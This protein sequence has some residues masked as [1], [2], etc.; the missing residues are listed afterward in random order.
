VCKYR[1]IFH[2]RKKI[3]KND[4]ARN[5]VYPAKKHRKSTGYKMFLYLHFKDFPMEIILIIIVLV[6]LVY[7]NNSLS[8]RIQKFEWRIMELTTLIE[9][10]KAEQKPTEA[11]APQTRPSPPVATPD[12]VPVPVKEEKPFEIITEK[13]ALPAPAIH[14]SP[15]PEHTPAPPP[16]REIQKSAWEKFK[17]KNPDL[18]KF[19][20]ENLINKIGVLILVLG[21]S[22]FVKF[23]I[24]KDWINEPARVG[25]GILCGALVMGFAHRLRKNFAAFSSVLVAGA[26]SIFYFTIGIAFHDYHLFGQTAAFILMVLITAFSSIISLSYNRLELAILTLIGGFAVP[27]MV[28][29]GEGNFIILFSY[30]AILDAG[31]LAIAYHKKWK[32][33]NLLSYIFTILLYG[34]WLINDLS[35]EHPHYMGALLFGFLFYLMFI[36]INI[37]NNIRTKGAFSATQL[38]M[39]VSNTFLFYA[40]GMAIFSGFHPEMRGLFT[41]CLALLNFVYAWFLYKRFGADKTTVYLLVGMTLTFVTLAIPIQFEGNFITLFW[42]AEAVLLMWLGRKSG[43]PGFRFASAAVHLLMIISLTMDWA[44]KYSGAET[45]KIIINPAFVTGI[46]AVLSLAAVSAIL[47]GDSG[48]EEKTRWLFPTMRYRT[49]VMIIAVALGYL[50]G[51]FEISHQAVAYMETHAAAK[52]LPVVYHLLFCSA[53]VFFLMWRKNAASYQAITLIAALNIVLYA[54]WFSR[55]PYLEHNEYIRT[56]VAQQTAFYLHYAALLLIIYLALQLYHSVRYLK[57]AQPGNRNAFVWISAFFLIYIASSELMLHW[58]V[59]A[60]NPVTPQDLQVAANDPIIGTGDAESMLYTTAEAKT[61]LAKLQ[62]MKT[63]FPI[64]WGVIAFLFL[65]SGIRKKSR[66]LRIISLTLLGITIVKLFLYDIRNASETGKIIAF[67]L[68]G[69]LILVISFVYQKLKV[70]VLNDSQPSDNEF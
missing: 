52:M 41:T 45:L 66:Q 62:A 21:I 1:I 47:K 17:E 14:T 63:G 23:A 5:R 44:D 12:P 8:A 65:I 3:F 68:L 32:L 10:L 54:F 37:I 22:Y 30:I 50:T 55:Y 59:I 29:T 46:F 39:L 40:A 36:L 38:G 64:L 2:F 70:L 58:L 53:L 42:A 56:N 16:V 18:E 24:D 34:G 28:S 6:F 57:T 43:M 19:I 27:F 48:T 51:I 7:I 20:G 49:I 61:S 33:L 26:I 35:S 13:P 9:K 15:E 31:I 25:I 69:I 11:P 67:I 4:M 60:N